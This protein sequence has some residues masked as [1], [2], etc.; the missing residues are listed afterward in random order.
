M[1]V[2]RRPVCLTIG[3]SDSS[4]GAGIQADLRVFEALGVHGCSAITAL[5]AQHP[6]AISRIEPVSL[7][8][9]E[10]EL[11]ALFDYYA[12]AMVKTGMLL[13]AERIALISGVLGERHKGGLVVDPVMV[14][15]S[16]KRLLHEAA[17]DTLV[18]ALLPQATLVTPNLDEAAVFLGVDVGDPVAAAVGLAERLGTAVLLKGGHRETEILVDVLAERDGRTREFTHCRQSWSLDQR[19][20]TGCRL[21]SAVAA[22]LTQQL[23]LSQAVENAISYLQGMSS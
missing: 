20:G 23:P 5:T 3:G 22:G 6:G 12:I 10:A 17:V 18:K 19:H 14:S 4:G 21:A 1:G 13:D 11:H 16:G 8:Q 7:A 2:D 15:S 9:I